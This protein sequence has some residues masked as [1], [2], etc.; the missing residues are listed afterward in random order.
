MTE[1]LSAGAALLYGMSAKYKE[2][3]GRFSAAFFVPYVPKDR[4]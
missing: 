1:R 3:M 4:K 2:K